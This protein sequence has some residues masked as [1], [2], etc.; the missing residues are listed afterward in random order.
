MLNDYTRHW[1]RNM[2][3]MWISQLLVMSGFDAAMPFIPQLLRDNFGMIDEHSRGVCVA[4]FTFAG[5]G[6]LPAVSR[7]SVLP[8]T[9]PIQSPAG[10]AAWTVALLAVLWVIAL[11]AGRGAGRRK[12]TDK[13][14][15]D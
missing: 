9:T 3:L 6:V 12:H 10:A 7:K 14:A 11:L 13:P 2:I 15:H 1:V 4:I 8:W 5:K